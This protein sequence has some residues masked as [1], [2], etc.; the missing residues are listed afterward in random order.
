MVLVGEAPSHKQSGI[1][2]PLIIFWQSLSPCAHVGLTVYDGLFALVADSPK[3]QWQGL[4]K[5]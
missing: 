2:I 1:P 5:R 3:F 4:P